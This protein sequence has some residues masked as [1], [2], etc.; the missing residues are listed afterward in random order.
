MTH[1]DRDVEF[2]T[3]KREVD[4]YIANSKEDL[5]SGYVSCEMMAKSLLERF[6]AEFV[7]VSED[8]ENGAIVT[9]A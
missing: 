7:E 6:R 8:G 1:D 2:I 9:R 5:F 3:L 4:I